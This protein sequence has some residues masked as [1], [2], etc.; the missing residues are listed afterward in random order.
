[1]LMVECVAPRCAD[2]EARSLGHLVS[3][4]FAPTV[5]LQNGGVVQPEEAELAT[6]VV[7]QRSLGVDEE[8]GFLLAYAQNP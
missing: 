5:V 8:V 6:F 7:R 2:M 1:M 3:L 4:P